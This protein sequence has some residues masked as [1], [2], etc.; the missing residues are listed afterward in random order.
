MGH[1]GDCTAA[2]GDDRCHV[3]RAVVRNEGRGE[4]VDGRMTGLALHH[5]HWRA[6]AVL[7]S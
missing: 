1:G 2:G 4:H 7:I 6:D 3:G 5:Q